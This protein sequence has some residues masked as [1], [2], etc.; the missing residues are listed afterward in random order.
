M[1]RQGELF[2]HSP[3]LDWLP[4]ETLFSLISRNHS[5]WGSA[6]PSRTASLLFSG[7]RRGTQHDLPGHLRAFAAV[8]EG[9]LGDAASIARERTLLRFY[10]GFLPEIDERTAVAD[11][12]AGNVKHLKLR[13]GLLTSRFR[14]NHPLKACLNCVLED[15]ARWGWAYWHLSHQFPGVWC[16]AEHGTP[17]CESLLKSTGVQR[18]FWILPG[19][20]H[21]RT[22]SPEEAEKFSVHQQAVL[23]LTR[24]ITEIVRCA[25]TRRIDL[26]LLHELYR[27]RIGEL[28]WLKR[29]GQFNWA[30]ISEAFLLHV[31]ELRFIPELQT[32]PETPEQAAVQLGRILRSPR[33]GTHPL[34]HLVII[35]WLFPDANRFLGAYEDHQAQRLCLPPPESEVRKIHSLM[36]PTDP[37]KERLLA[38]LRDGKLSM[39]SAATE[40][41]VTIATAMTWACSAGI[42]AQRRPKVLNADTREKLEMLLRTGSEKDAAAHAFGVSIQTVTRVLLTTVGLHE[43]WRQ[44]RLTKTRETYRR[45]WQNLCDEYPTAGVNILRG[46][47][48]AVHAWLYRN[49]REWLKDH[50]PVA[51]VHPVRR[52]ADSTWRGRDTEL[53]DAVKKAAFSLALDGTKRRI[54]LWELYQLVPALKPKLRV[55]ERLPLTRRAIENVLAWRASPSSLAFLLS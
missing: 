18:F 50:R 49:D 32:L 33:S 54:F 19:T 53:S 16:C 12:C 5:L 21:L 22:W 8:T 44:S 26:A 47:A 37:R 42:A 38:L 14:A 23:G 25:D 28:G 15:V 4:D 52:L 51:M 40:I 31:R 30:L 39:R 20:N 3:M 2:G 11:M 46:M 17:L 45:D 48:D 36:T 29:G 6:D 7:S 1:L 27:R 43:A 10:R 55:L 9:R 24:L 41:G 35:N 34:R 13:L